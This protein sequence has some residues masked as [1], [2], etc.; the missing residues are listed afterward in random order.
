MLAE[1]VLL[2]VAAALPS[3][4]S[5]LGAS[6]RVVALVAEHGPTLAR[7]LGSALA[8][9]DRGEQP[10]VIVRADYPDLGRVALEAEGIS[11]LA[12]TEPPP[13]PPTERDL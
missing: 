8:V 11:P 9:L 13:A 10:L 12:Q 6:A 4:L 7:L 3:L 5:T 1:S 2:G